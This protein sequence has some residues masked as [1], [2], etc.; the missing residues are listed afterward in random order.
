MKI[1]LTRLSIALMLILSSCHQEIKSEK[2]GIDIISNVYFNASKGL[3]EMQSFHI[4][5][6]S[7]SEDDLI[8]IV[9]DRSF[10]EMSKQIYYIN[11][12]LCYPIG[13]ERKTTI[14]SEIALKQKPLLVWQKKEGAVFSKEWIPNYRNR[15]KLSDTILFGKQYKRFEINSPWNY[16]RF[17]IYPTDTILP[18]SLY[19]HAEQDYHGRL[20]RIDS[21]NKKNDIF[22]TLQLIPR[23]SWDES[24]RELFEFNRFVTRTKNE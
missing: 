8:E 10:P 18:Y 11:D 15:R 9:P 5:K 21:Y 7:Y 19:R 16:T 12:S 3:D 6:I 24:A 17:Y 22:V 13:S 1:K 4:S 20:E 23:K 14:L 2:G